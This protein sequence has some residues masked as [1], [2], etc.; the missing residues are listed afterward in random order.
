LLAEI[1]GGSPLLVGALHFFC[2]VLEHLLIQEHLG[3]QPLE[4]INLAL[5]FAASAIGVDLV[6]VVLLSPP[7]IGCLRD[8]NLST[9][10]RDV[11]S[12]SQLAIGF[13]WQSRQFIG[14]PSPSHESLRD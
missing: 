7:I 12:L 14:G 9:D 4:P 2:D 13:T 1:I 11:Q 10:V 3:D 8:A 6:G 5:E